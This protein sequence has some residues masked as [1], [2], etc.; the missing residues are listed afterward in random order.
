MDQLFE[1]IGNHALLVGT[2]VTLLLLFFAIESR[3]GGTSVNPQELVNL[4]NRENAV[5][6]DVRTSEEFRSGHIVNAINIPYATLHTRGKELQAYRDRPV[7]VTCKL[8]QH[9][10]AAGALLRKIGLDRV[11]RLSGGMM[12]WQNA[13]LPVVKD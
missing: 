11:A 1:F 5:V 2:F 10:G 6:L 7:V 12:G 8:G 9:A 4:V 13:A 3:R